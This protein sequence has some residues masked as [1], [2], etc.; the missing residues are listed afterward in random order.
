MVAVR[1]DT[2]ALLEYKQPPAFDAYDELRKAILLQRERVRLGYA[3]ELR[4]ELPI[5]S[6]SR[7]IRLLVEML[8]AYAKL[9]FELGIREYKGPITQYRG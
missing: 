1:P 4:M 2:G 7:D 9:E 6:L 3:Q 8:M 5:L